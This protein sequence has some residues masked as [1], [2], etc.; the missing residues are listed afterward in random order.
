MSTSTHEFNRDNGLPTF[1]PP[2]TT[3]EAR[4]RIAELNSAIKSIEDQI[5]VR[6]MS[7]TLNPEWLKKATTS[8]R[9]K[10]LERDR[11]LN[12]IEDYNADVTSGK[13]LNDFIVS[14]V[15]EDYSDEEW[16]CVV[17]DARAVMRI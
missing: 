8:Q 17:A 5:L 4:N 10:T 2:I 13:N 14:V 6:E 7:D 16:E 15:R 11:L 1:N 9:F 3:S 12:W